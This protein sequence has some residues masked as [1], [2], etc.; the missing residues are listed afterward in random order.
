MP[1][2]TARIRELVSDLFGKECLHDMA[3]EDTVVRGAAILG[4]ILSDDA[5]SEDLCVM[6]V[7][8]LSL[9]VEITGGAI[10]KLIPRNSIMP[11]RKSMTFTTVKDWQ[12][13][14]RIKV[15]EG[16][17]VFAEHD[18][19]LGEFTLSGITS[20]TQGVPEVEVV[21]EV[22]ADGILRTSATELAR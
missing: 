3:P 9:G 4:G 8:P 6:P 11:I 5:V 22:D 1:D 10:V 21:M 20:A 12:S 18:N 7:I 2:Q 13:S 16:E 17:C 14:I 19:F 15:F